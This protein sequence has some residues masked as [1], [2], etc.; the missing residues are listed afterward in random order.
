MLFL[1]GRPT[2]G[3]TKRLFSTRYGGTFPVRG[4]DIAADGRF[5]MPL[6]EAVPTSVPTVTTHLDIILKWHRGLFFGSPSQKSPRS[7]DGS[8]LRL[9]IEGCRA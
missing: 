3:K 5:L 7:G 2:L 8:T 6:G 9:A 4:Y 1:S